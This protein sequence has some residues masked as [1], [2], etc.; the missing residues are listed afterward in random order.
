MKNNCNI[1]KDLLAVYAVGECSE[2]TTALVTE[3]LETCEGCRAQLEAYTSVP[4]VPAT[5]EKKSFTAFSRK[6]KI[7][8]LRKVIIST[9]L[10]LAVLCGIG[11]LCL[12]PEY[13]ISC[14][15]AL[16]DVTVPVDGGLDIT[17]GCPN[18]KEAYATFVRSED[19]DIDVYI[20]AANNV[21]TSIIPDPDRT[22]NFLRIGNGI[23]VSY[24]NDGRVMFCAPAGSNADIRSEVR[25][26]YYVEVPSTELMVMDEIQLGAIEYKVLLW[27]QS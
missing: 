10:V 5:D 14:K 7:R 24:K 25:R 23:C 20:T 18:Y 9:V 11:A 19:G 22:D 26:V 12:V 1:I 8:N 16:V 2:D 27:E 17:F 13:T 4:E 15:D 3:H 6:L 21:F